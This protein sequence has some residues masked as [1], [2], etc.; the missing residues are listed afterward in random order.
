MLRAFLAR[1]RVRSGESLSTIAQK[2]GARVSNVQRANNMGG[3]TM[4]RAGQVLLVPVGHQYAGAAS[5]RS[6]RHRVQRGDSLWKIAMRYNVSIKDLMAW[7]GLNSKS[8]L[9]PGDRILVKTGGG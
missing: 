4:I 9:R 5:G 2:Y 3:R 7:N 6:V 1:H 8:I